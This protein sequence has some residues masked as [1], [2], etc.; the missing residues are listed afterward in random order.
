MAKTEC[1][2]TRE[3]VEQIRLNRVAL[4]NVDHVMCLGSGINDVGTTDKYVD[5]QV[6]AAWS[7]WRKLTTVL[8]DK[9]IP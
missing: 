2:K 5:L 3:T 7:N 4:R 1:P 9:K 6:Q 8:Y